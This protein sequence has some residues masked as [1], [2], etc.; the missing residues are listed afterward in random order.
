MQSSPPRPTET[1]AT[2]ATVMSCDAGATQ[3][4]LPNVAGMTYR[5][6]AAELTRLGASPEPLLE[7]TPWGTTTDADPV[8]NQRT[9]FQPGPLHVVQNGDTLA[10]IAAAAGLTVDQ[11][12]AYNGVESDAWLLVA[13]APPHA[14]PRP[15]TDDIGHVCRSG[16]F[17][18]PDA[19]SRVLEGLR[20]A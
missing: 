7:L 15:A 17:S 8:V 9:A 14:A 18:A 1:S 19:L 3:I 13:C 6:A 10:S 12:V 11:L 16:S 5:D 20:S 4:E 2:R